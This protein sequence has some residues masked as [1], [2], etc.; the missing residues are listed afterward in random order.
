LQKNILYR[1]KS[2]VVNGEFSF[3]FLVPKDISFATGPGRIS[4]YATNG[5][6]DASGY[7]DKVVVGGDSKNIVIDTEG[8]KVNLYLNDKSFINGSITNEKPILYAEISDSSG[9]NTLGSGI[10]HDLSLVLDEAG[11]KPIILNDYY[12]ANL[13]SYQIGRVKYPFSDLSEGNHR[14]S[15]KVWDIQ[16]NSNTVYTD[17]VV[18]KSAKLA[19][20]HVLNYPNPFTNHTTFMFEHNQACNPLKLVIQIYTI[21]GKLVKTIQ[22]QVTC[23]G[24]K[25]EGIEWDGKDDF[26]DKLGRGVYLYKL[27]IS[28]SENQ[29]AE[30]IEKLVILN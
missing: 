20:D 9:V 5:L 14:L 1:G 2:Q 11:N 26:N 15:L 10:G 21:T 27:S 23:Q 4:Y 6:I 24:F 25:N 28:D 3:T 13:N 16:N 7:Y 22:E 12:E 19:L 29:K 30:K 18:A 8:P 17:F